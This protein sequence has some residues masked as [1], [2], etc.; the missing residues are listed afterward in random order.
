MQ[1]TLASEITVWHICI[2]TAPPE[3]HHDQCLNM[4]LS[5][6]GESTCTRCRDIC[7]VHAIDL[8]EQH[9]PHLDEDRC[10]DCTACVHMCPS[11]AIHHEK[12][13][14]VSIVKQAYEL[15]RQGKTSLHATCSAV[16]DTPADV[17]VPCHAA[18]DPILLACV[19][20]EGIR[21]LYLNGIHQCSSCPVRHGA[22][23][24]V[25]TEKDYALLSKA[26]DT[27]LEISREEITI[28]VEQTRRSVPEPERRTFFRN[29]FPMMAH[30]AIQAAAQLNQVNNDEDNGA[31]TVTP[32][33]LPLRLR[34]FLRALPRLQANFT[35]VPS[36]PSFPLG[37]IQVDANCT[38]CNECVE[39]CS[40]HAL[41]L[42]E[43]GTS[44]VLEFRLDAC[45]GC[46]QCVDICPEHAIEALPTI[47]LPVLL[48]RRTRPL[49]IVAS[50]KIAKK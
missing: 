50:G 30:G 21:T 26:F 8:N 1:F 33:R 35:P 27:H 24:M 48:T 45:M 23:I 10:T 40:T 15:A 43:L 37:A 29:L 25:Q 4:H 46:R 9:L 7:P 5:N 13:D 42:K 6:A 34:L 3:I 14:P 39:Q 47:S 41:E 38:A 19:A 17:S 31:G 16:A 28:P 11:D 18:W 32:T 22:E 20:A 36:M 12:I 2:M 44:K 49:V